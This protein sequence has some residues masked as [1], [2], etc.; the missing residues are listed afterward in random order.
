MATLEALKTKT[1]ITGATELSIIVAE[2]AVLRNLE[3]T[4]HFEGKWNGRLVERWATIKDRFDPFKDAV[5]AQ[6][7]NPHLSVENT[8]REFTMKV[9]LEV[10]PRQLLALQDFGSPLRQR[11]EDLEEECRVL[12]LPDP[13]QRC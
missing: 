1:I 9:L 10:I 2:L 5:Q 3:D 6:I 13:K 12:L 8:Q 11:I 4:K 7:N